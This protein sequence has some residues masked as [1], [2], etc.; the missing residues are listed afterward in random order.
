MNQ[1]EFYI[2]Y[3][4]GKAKYVVSYHDGIK[5]HSDESNFFDIKIFKN[6]KLLNV[7]VNELKS[8]GYIEK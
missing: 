8:E 7:F 5:K 3:N 6:K 1:K 2:Q 4:I